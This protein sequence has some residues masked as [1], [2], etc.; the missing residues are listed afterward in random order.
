VLVSKLG[1]VFLILA[2]LVGAVLFYAWRKS[3]QPGAPPGGMWGTVNSWWGSASNLTQ[4]ATEKTIKL[5]STW[6]SG[7]GSGVR[8]ANSLISDSV[9]KGVHIGGNLNPLNWF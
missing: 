1:T 8:G 9:N 4:D 7:L 6:G 2:A 3:T 5:G